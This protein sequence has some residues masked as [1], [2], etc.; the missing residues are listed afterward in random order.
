M[1]LPDFLVVGAP[2]AGTTALHVALAGHPQLCLSDIKEPKYFLVDGPP[3]TGGG[4]GD[5]K[6]YSE[7]VWR[8]EDYEKLWDHAGPDQLRGESTTLYLQ[9]PQA[10]VRIHRTVPKVKLIAVLRDPVDRAHSNWS[11]LRSAGLEP[12]ADFPRACMLGERRGADGWGPFW[13]YLEIGRYGAQL[14]H[15][16]SVFP[17][18]QVLVLLYRELREQPIRALD[19][20]CSFLGIETG[21]LKEL[22]SENVTA[23]VSEGLLNSALHK[24]V[25]RVE[26]WRG[27]APA[28]V[29]HA[30]TSLAVKLLQR[31]QRTR[32]SL[33]FE[34][35]CL[36]LPH[37]SDDLDRLERITGQSFAH[38]RDPQNGLT[39]RPL[40]IGGRF[41]TAFTS[42]DRP[43]KN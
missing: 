2:K 39:R 4:P 23:Q 6:T 12:I 36:L 20:V 19:R 13:R 29:R 42:I 17:R 9:D 33:T 27:I 22:P 30:T 37:F 28:P 31:D 5:A 14:E 26:S 18:E 24:T 21:H 35:R 3:P 15:L 7:Y 43:T 32:Q 38:W 16:Y 41:G 8:R 34:E 1:A 10:H 40:D 25:Q 11:H